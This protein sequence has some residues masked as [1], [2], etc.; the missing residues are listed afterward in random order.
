MAPL[1]HA[2]VSL[3][4]SLLAFG[5]AVIESK[6]ETE[7]T[8][9]SCVGQ[10]TDCWDTIDTPPSSTPFPPRVGVGVNEIER[11]PLLAVAPFER[12]LLFAAGQ[13]TKEGKEKQPATRALSGAPSCRETI[14]GRLLLHNYHT[15]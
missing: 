1:P 4:F 7:M 5:A 11:N 12:L 8:T 14:L 2:K 15:A 13:K 6:T 9:V 3:Y 10:G